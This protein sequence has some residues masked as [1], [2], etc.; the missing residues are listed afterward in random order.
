MGCDY[1]TTLKYNADELFE[2]WDQ[3][4]HVFIFATRQKNMLD[5]AIWEKDVTFS[6]CLVIL[7]LNGL[8]IGLVS[9][10][11]VGQYAMYRLRCF[12]AIHSEF[13]LLLC[14]W[15]SRLNCYFCLYVYCKCCLL[16]MLMFQVFSHHSKVIAPRSR[17]VGLLVTRA[18]SAADRYG[19]R[20]TD[21]EWQLF[22]LSV[23]KTFQ[24]N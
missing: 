9:L 20:V 19:R 1:N 24:K 12:F 6:K 3:Q 11:V 7:S 23:S 17:T 22:S 14:S 13:V 21:N 10:Y 4:L 18:T 8:D 15:F 2:M 5:P 16:T